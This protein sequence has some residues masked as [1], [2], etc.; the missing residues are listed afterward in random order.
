MPAL[1]HRRP[2]PPEPRQDWTVTEEH[3]VTL[4]KRTYTLTPGVEFSVIRKVG[5]TGKV[6]RD[7]LSFRR[8]VR[9]ATGAEWLEAYDAHRC[10]LRSVKVD[11]VD[12]VHRTRRISTR[13]IQAGAA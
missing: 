5:T 13:S 10:Q 3:A 6:Y 8:H 9:T 1:R 7:R 2:V 4:G 11:R 12:V